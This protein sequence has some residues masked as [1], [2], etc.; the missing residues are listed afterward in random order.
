M[1]WFHEDL[2]KKVIP[3]EDFAENLKTI[4]AVSRERGGDAVLVSEFWGEPFVTSRDFDGVAFYKTMEKAAKES[5]AHFVDMYQTLASNYDP[6]TL[7][8]A[9]DVVHANYEGHRLIAQHLFDY[10]AKNKL[11]PATPDLAD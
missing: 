10:L 8:F 6:L 9:D 4:V 3:P 5:D 7:V 11:I 1:K 2:L